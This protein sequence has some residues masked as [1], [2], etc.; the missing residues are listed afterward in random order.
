M[1]TSALAIALHNKGYK[2]TGSD[3]GFFPPVST[4]LERAGI[5]FYAG[6]HPELILSTS[7]GQ[8]GLP[9]E[10]IAGGGG[11]SLTNPELVAAKEKDIPILSL[12]EAVGKYIVKPKSIVT[13]GTWGKTTTSALLSFILKEAGWQPSYFTGGISL[14]H[15]T[16]AIGEA[17]P[18]GGWS[19][20]EGDEY[21][22]AIWDTKPKFAY[23]APTHLLLT[24]VS[25]DHADLYPTEDS[26]FEVFEKLVESIPEDGLI[27]A[28][29]DN[30]GV[31]KLIGHAKARVITYGTRTSADYKL[32]QVAESP[33]GLRFGICRGST[34]YAI[35]SPLLGSFQAENITGAFVLAKEIGVPIKDIIEGL[36]NFKGIK[37]RLEKRFESSQ[38]TVIDD[39]AHSPDKARA[40]LRTLRE[41]Y[42]GQIIAVFE[43]NIGAREPEAAVK[44]TDAF[45]AADEVIIPKFTKLKVDPNSPIKPLEGNDLAELIARSHSGVRYIPN[46]DDLVN[47][48]TNSA[49]RPPSEEH[50]VIAFLGSHGFRNMIETTIEKLKN[51]TG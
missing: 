9:D 46:D 29:I 48:L 11:T 4:N 10:V 1:A 39:I 37:R 23:Y 13:T 41:I 17:P 47:E 36:A 38:L 7:S 5:S 8:V 43:P 20:V 45:S 44:Y 49:S 35:N 6:W 15:D 28:C 51:V 16:G 22:A 42:G 30:P 34:C 31:R 33:E 12:A 18:A 26:Y 21:K 27:V 24:S 25:W 32:E 40:T 14:S 19:V 2:I 3:K 50:I